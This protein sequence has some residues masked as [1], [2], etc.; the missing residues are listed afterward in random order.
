MAAGT[1]GSTSKW[2]Q[3]VAKT[4]HEATLVQKTW[5]GV[6]ARRRFSELFYQ[7]LEA[8]L[9]AEAAAAA[10]LTL[11]DDGSTDGDDDDAPKTPVRERKAS[12]SLEEAQAEA[13]YNPA[14]SCF[15]HV[16][17]KPGAGGGAAAASK[18]A[19]QHKRTGSGTP[20]AGTTMSTWPCAFI[21]EQHGTRVAP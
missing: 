9:G 1:P 15:M 6:L 10:P 11:L 21:G 16:P 7:A 14:A 13:A 8:C 3:A 17:P 20:S 4:A 2:G 5:R 18:L 12:L 19:T